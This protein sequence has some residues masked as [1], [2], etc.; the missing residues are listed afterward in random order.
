[1][2]RRPLPPLSYV[3]I[4]YPFSMRVTDI[5]LTLIDAVVVPFDLFQVTG[6]V[7]NK[8]WMS[9]ETP[10]MG[11]RSWKAFGEFVIEK[12]RETYQKAALRCQ[13]LFNARQIGHEA[14]LRKQGVL[15]LL[16]DKIIS[17]MV[18]IRQPTTEFIGSAIV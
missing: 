7:R 10:K 9:Q 18:A 15:T 11:C 2:R 4:E 12:K 16:S 3:T 17:R 5:E 6:D 8:C 1:V 13:S 14:T